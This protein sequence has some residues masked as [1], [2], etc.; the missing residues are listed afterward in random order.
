MK[1]KCII[2]IWCQRIFYHLTYT[3]SNSLSTSLLTAGEQNTLK[4]Q[5]KYK[6]VILNWH[7]PGISC[8]K[9][10]S[11][12]NLFLCCIIYKNCALKWRWLPCLESTVQVVHNISTCQVL[13]LAFSW[14]VSTDCNIV[15]NLDNAAAYELK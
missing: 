3:F 8:I 2:C 6:L 4:K 15:K 12:I 14:Y 13:S 5:K 9:Q 7:Y 1:A 10:I 11:Y